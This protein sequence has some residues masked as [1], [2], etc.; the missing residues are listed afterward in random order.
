VSA[1]SI[2]E[3]TNSTGLWVPAPHEELPCRVTT[4]DL[5][6][7]DYPAQIEQAKQLCAQCPVQAECLSGALDRRE[8]AGVWG[9]QLFAGGVIVPFKRPR[10]R[11][12]KNA[13]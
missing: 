9:G 4:A 13:A 12:R 6:F 8:H 3:T 1:Q 11:P 10:G 2:Q 7:S 5:W